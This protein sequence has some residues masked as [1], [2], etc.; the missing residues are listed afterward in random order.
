M[1]S[2]FGGPSPVQIYVAKVRW[3]VAGLSAT[4]LVL[5]ASLVA[6]VGQPQ[7]APAPVRDSPSR[8]QSPR[9]EVLV[10][11]GALS[12]GT[13]V[14]DTVLTTVAL[15]SE[16]LPEG[17]VLDRDR[18][19]IYGKFLRAG[20]PGG[21][22]ISQQD[23]SDTPPISSV[24]IPPG[25]RLVA[26]LVDATTAVDGFVIPNT[27][28]DVIWSFTD[29]DGQRQIAKIVPTAK[30]VS[31]DGKRNREQNGRHEISEQNRSR[32]SL[33][34]SDEDAQRIEYARASGTLSLVLV[35]D[36]HIDE[37]RSASVSTMNKDKVLRQAAPE[38]KADGHLSLIENGQRVTRQLIDG[39]WQDVR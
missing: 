9:I 37:P 6:V 12:A 2:R 26:I 22:F 36:G 33:L 17:V 13:E 31:V 10:S 34:V 19:S 25:M 23:L 7:A 20:L 27:R 29:K 28:V 4:I 5:V 16:E 18:L 15:S 21:H 39:V 11:R 38:R 24:P 32:V 35:G 8:F 30:V 3:I 14:N 1:G